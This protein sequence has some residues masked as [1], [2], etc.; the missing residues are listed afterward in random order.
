MMKLSVSQV[1]SAR[2]S[3]ALA[4][5]AVLLT[6]ACSS[7]SSSGTGSSSTSSVTPTVA[8]HDVAAV[9]AAAQAFSASLD[10][11]QKEL[12]VL[13]LTADN[14]EAWS[15]LP[16]GQSCRGGVPFEDLDDN[17][18]ALARVLLQ[19]AIGT[20]DPGYPRVEDLWAADDELSSLQSSGEGGEPGSGSTAGSTAGGAMPSGSG[21]PSG[22]SAPS[23]S[24]MPSGDMP[25]GDMPTGDMPSGGSM[26][27]GS[28]G[29]AGG[30][31]GGGGGYGAGLYDLA[32]L[33]DPD[34]DGT[35][36]L[37]FGGHHLA[38]NFTYE[39]G[40]VAGSSPYFVGLE[41]TTW[42]A[43]DGT[44]YAPLEAMKSAV[45]ALST[46]L[47]TAQKKQ[48]ELS[49]TFSDVLLG[50]GEDGQFPAKKQGIA[51][52]RLTDDQQSAVLDVLRQ[53]VGIADDTTAESMLK[54]YED[55]L[56]KTYVGWSG[57]VEMTAHANYLRIDGP[58]AW[59]EF[60]CQ[61]GVVLT[62]KIHYHTVWRDHTRDYGG[63]FSS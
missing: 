1:F 2:G 50:P 59:V 54:T 6:A 27:S 37:H 33:G 46:S 49:Q 4:A 22:G 62:D 45:T 44:E 55:E 13:D 31:G 57:G 23:D 42:T 17:Q 9:V 63:E 15:N 29:G 19:S 24:G 36:M 10:D 12:A 48:A 28:G 14:A 8:G 26:P 38:V 40:E 56:S 30:G 47:T 53:W 43:D 52:S 35:W 34:T 58:S 32:L 21:A 20:G 5:A 16:S 51:A 18:L 39:A 61:N 7:S 60:V 11:D 25:T 3:G 41:P